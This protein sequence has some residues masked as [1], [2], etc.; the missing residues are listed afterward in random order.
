MAAGV[1]PRDIAS[2]SSRLELQ[3]DPRWGL[4][5]VWQNWF[6]ESHAVWDFLAA[7]GEEVASLYFLDLKSEED[8]RFNWC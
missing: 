8:F 2:V 1:A 4:I 6:S 7:A 3:K 5:I